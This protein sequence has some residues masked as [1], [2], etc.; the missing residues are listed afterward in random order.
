MK[1]TKKRRTARPK[2]A[3]SQ[4]AGRGSA[5]D[6]VVQ[7]VKAMVDPFNTPKG[8]ASYLGD[9]RPSQKF[10]AK[11]NTTI[12]VP[13]GCT[14][15]FMA[16]PCLC[17]NSGSASIV[18]GIQSAQGTALSGPWKNGNTGNLVLT[19]GTIA[20][21]STNT[22]YDDATL[23]NMMAL[24]YCVG[25]GYRFTYEGPELYRSGTFKYVHDGDGFFNDAAGVQL[26]DWTNSSSGPAQVVTYVDSAANSIR[27]SI[28]RSNVVEINGHTL[29][30]QFSQGGWYGAMSGAT[31]GGTTA[32]TVF[33]VKPSLLGYFLNSSSSAVSF[34]IETVEHYA[35]T[36]TSI[37]ALHTESTAHN[38]LMGQVAG[39]LRN[40][41][42]MHA[43]KPNSTHI[44]ALKLANR[45]AGSKLGHEALEA[46][47][48]AALA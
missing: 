48:T 20:R 5:T 2:S 38:A 9:A 40:A 4:Q 44:D 16:A 19:G 8:I 12:S 17:S 23:N 41:R 13:A 26:N 34:H 22:P 15:V 47:M 28:N 29:W 39:A 1:A 11:A 18:M 37:Q 36:A 6:P 35:V 7:S 30:G 25:V 14:M 43:S 45:A 31:I 42:Q 10:M 24:G 3:R 46:A 33:S 27:Q 21:L 32:D